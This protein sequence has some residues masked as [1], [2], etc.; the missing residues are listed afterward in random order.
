MQMRGFDLKRV[1]KQCE[2]HSCRRMHP[3]DWQ[4]A[5][6]PAGRPAGAAGGR[7]RQAAHSLRPH[8]PGG[9]QVCLQPQQSSPPESGLCSCIV[10][11]QC[12]MRGR[13]ERSPCMWVLAHISI[14]HHLVYAACQ[15]GFLDD[16]TGLLGAQCSCDRPLIRVLVLA[17]ACRRGGCCG[18]RAGRPPALRPHGGAMWAAARRAGSA[19]IAPPHSSRPPGAATRSARPSWRTG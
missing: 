12:T 18:M 19:A 11:L 3:A 16:T 8:H 13:H 2:P 17:G 9:L 15:E 14:L 6:V 4:D 1:A 10:K 7:S 5:G